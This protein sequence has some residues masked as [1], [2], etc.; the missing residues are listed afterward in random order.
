MGT[1]D[2]DTT[3]IVDFEDG[4]ANSPDDVDASLEEIVTQYNA[5][6]NKTTGHYHDGTNSR[7]VYGGIT[8]F[9]TEEMFLLM[10][11]GAFRRGGL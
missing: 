3:E 7:L 6:M 2:I 5:S 4:T 11:C 9:T 1:F 8:G 10:L